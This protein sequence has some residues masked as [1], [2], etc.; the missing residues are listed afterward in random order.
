MI[1]V[2][3]TCLVLY[4]L[5]VRSV[6]YRKLRTTLW[7]FS[8]GDLEKMTPYVAQQIV[9]VSFL[10]DTPYTMLMGTRVALFKVYGIRSIASVLLKSGELTSKEDEKINKRLADTAILIA[11]ALSNPVLG[12]GS[13]CPVTTPDSDPRSA[14]AIARINYLHKKYNIR[15]DDFL[16]NLSLFMIEPIKFTEKYDW[17]PHSPLEIQAIFVLWTEVGRRMGIQNIWNSYE[18]MVEWA[19]VGKN[20]SSSGDSILMSKSFSVIHQQQ[21]ELDNMI[22]SEESQKLARVTLEHFLSR[23]PRIPGLRGLVLQ[24]F[25]TLLDART[26]NAMG[27]SEPAPTIVKLVHGIFALRAFLVR[28]F[29]LPRGKPSLWVKLDSTHKL[30]E[31]GVPRIPAAFKRREGPWYYPEATGLWLLKDRILVSLGLQNVHKLPG[32]RWRSEG[33]RL[34]ELGP[35]QFEKS[36]HRE[37]MEEAQ[38]IQGCPTA[39]LWGL[40]TD[41]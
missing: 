13:G 39:G 31:V 11:T 38:R 27:L 9:H 22:P 21:Y 5:V 29:M 30:D 26:R 15:N 6:R 37:V 20:P 19:N 8:R 25:T 23:V 18:E 36:G 16:Y 10:Y 12:P 33:Y 1:G 7:K 28:N 3:A 34:E 32:K 2:L 17:R 40:P 4:A 14:I 35:V 41:S 24:I